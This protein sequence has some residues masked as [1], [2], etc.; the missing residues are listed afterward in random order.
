M[1]CDEGTA[2]RAGDV[3]VA[4]LVGAGRARSDVT[5]PTLNAY[6]TVTVDRARAEA[7]SRDAEL[8]ALAT[9]KK[10]IIE[11][12]GGGAAAASFL[13][14]GA[15]AKV[16]GAP[17]NRRGGGNP[18]HRAPAPKPMARTRLPPPQGRAGATPVPPGG[19]SRLSRAGYR[20]ISPPPARARGRH[21]PAAS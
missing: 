1:R 6:I 18:R 4:D 5:E 12:V 20:L 7:A 19:A 8:E 11:K 2:L 14:L 16:R 13:Q 10:I 3:T 21:G 15:S 17:V 9:A